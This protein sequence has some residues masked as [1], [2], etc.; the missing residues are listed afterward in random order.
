MYEDDDQL[1]ITL[2]TQQ[3]RRVRSEERK[4]RKSALSQQDAATS[5][6]LPQTEDSSEAHSHDEYHE[7]HH[8]EHREHHEHHHGEHHHSEHR[9]HHHGEHR[10]HRHGEHHH[11]EGSGGDGSRHGSGSGHRRT[12]QDYGTLTLGC[13]D[14]AQ[15]EAP[16]AEAAAEAPSQGQLQKEFYNKYDAALSRR[17]H[18][19][20]KF[21]V[22]RI[23]IIVLLA[24]L[25]LILS[26]VGLGNLTGQTAET[27]A[28]PP[29]ETLPVETLDLGG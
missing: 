16:E 17:Y 27:L 1:H 6:A 18:T 8:S 12:Y 15:E 26:L 10:E 5:D 7:H 21:K 3:R 2:V 28:R 11:S 24:G 23:L 25:V 29:V 4:G 19:R 22:N 13:M 9:T 20:N 14:G